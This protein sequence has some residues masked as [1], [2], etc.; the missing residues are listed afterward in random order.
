M[1]WI[2][3]HYK[4]LIKVERQEISI[5]RIKGYSVNEIAIELGRHRSTVHRELKRNTVAGK[6]IGKKAQHKAYVRRKYSKYQSM[7][8]VKDMKLRQYIETKLLIEDWSP[9][10]IAGRLAHES[11]LEKVSTPSIYKYIRSVYGR[12]LEYELQLAKQKRKKKC[13]QKVTK[14]EDRIF[15][16]K[17][18][19][20]AN[21]RAQY[22]HWEG[23]F[24]VSGKQYGNTSLLVLHER[25]SR[26]TFIRKIDART[27]QNVEDVISKAVKQLGSFKSLT[28]DNDIAFK[29]HIKLTELLK[30]PVYFCQPYHSWEKGGVEN[31]NRLIRRY[32]PKGCDISKYSDDEITKIE[33]K[34]NNLPRKILD[35]QT[36]Q[37]TINEYRQGAILCQ[38]N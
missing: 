30:A 37:E 18:P 28:L 2:M 25:V 6:Y 8:I 9:E 11:G 27:V 4:Q 1:W 34:I 7:C 23:D 16:D 24:I 10:Q 5:L 19:E 20:A 22:G 13:Q 15:I 33:Q 21:I 35:F 17:R 14:L 31:V 26:Y 38:S 3:K 32:I 36:A 29:R 12:Q